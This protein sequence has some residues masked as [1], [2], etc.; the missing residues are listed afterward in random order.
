MDKTIRDLR[1]KVYRKLVTDVPQ[2]VIQ[3]DPAFI[4]GVMYPLYVMCVIDFSD[5]SVKYPSGL[6]TPCLSHCTIWRLRI[7]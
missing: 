7:V 4:L 3:R 5:L 6:K 1:N 2:D